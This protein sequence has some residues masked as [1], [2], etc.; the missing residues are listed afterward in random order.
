MSTTQVDRRRITPWLCDWVRQE[1]SRSKEE[2]S[3]PARLVQITSRGGPFW[4]L[5]NE[6]AAAHVMVTDG[7]YSIRLELDMDDRWRV[8]KQGLDSYS[9]GCCGP[10]NAW[11]LCAAQRRRR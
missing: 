2:A 6:E 3:P 4:E 8:L 10:W 11:R 1:L 5:E 9:R 7:D